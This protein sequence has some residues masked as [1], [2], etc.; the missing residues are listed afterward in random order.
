MNTNMANFVGNERSPLDNILRYLAA[1]CAALV[2][3][4]SPS[5]LKSCVSFREKGHDEIKVLNCSMHQ[6]IGVKRVNAICY[7]LAVHSS[8]GI[9]N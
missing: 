5:T 3:E 6:C 9:A 8:G 2:I 7:E 4:Q 1:D